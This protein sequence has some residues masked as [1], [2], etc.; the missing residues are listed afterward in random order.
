MRYLFCPQCGKKL[1]ERKLGDDGMVP[2]CGDCGRPWFDSFYSCVIVLTYNEK[3]EIVL[4]RERF[5]PRETMGITAGYMKPGES[6]EEAALREVREEL[7]IR[8]E[9]LEYAGTYWFPYNELLMHGFIGYTPRQELKVSEELESAAWFP[10]LEAPKY[11]HPERP[12]T[13]MHPIYR[14]FLQKRG[15]TAPLNGG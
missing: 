1:E 10:A 5:R 9:S 3:D 13:A 2:F 6:A 8:L 7:G 14:R 15:L 12:Q 4:C 11:M